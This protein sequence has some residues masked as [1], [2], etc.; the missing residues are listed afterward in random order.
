MA[1][2]SVY[3]S[4]ALGLD[5][6]VADQVVRCLADLGL[7]LDDPS[8]DETDHLFL[9]LEEFRQHL[10]GRLTLTMIPE[11]GKPI[12]VHEVDYQAMRRAI[13]VVRSRAREL[14]TPRVER[15]GA[16]VH[17]GGCSNAAEDAQLRAERPGSLLWSGR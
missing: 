12:D 7:P 11:V 8:L 14:G 6:E 15:T 17:P 4:I 2:D 5:P 9:G 10:G 13:D 16:P 1:I 3:S